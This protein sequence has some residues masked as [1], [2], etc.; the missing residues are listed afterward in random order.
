MG[1]ASLAFEN[2]EAL[3]ELWK[4]ADEGVPVRRDTIK[5]LAA[6]KQES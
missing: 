3:F 6:L 4:N 5:R 2:Y 1:E